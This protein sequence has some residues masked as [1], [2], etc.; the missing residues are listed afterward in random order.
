MVHLVGGGRKEL[1]TESKDMDESQLRKRSG[2]GQGAKDGGGEVC[3][4]LVLRSF[5]DQY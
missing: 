5:G 1:G 4:V 3:F 2:A